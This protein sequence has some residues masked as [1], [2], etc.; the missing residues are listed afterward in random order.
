M[1]GRKRFELRRLLALWN[2]G[3]SVFSLVGAIRLIPEMFR[4]LNEDNGFHKSICDLR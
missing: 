3:L 4:I 1:D 2:I